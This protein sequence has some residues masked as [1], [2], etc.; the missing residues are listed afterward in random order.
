[1]RKLGFVVCAI[2]SSGLMFL[3]VRTAERNTEYAVFE[4]ARNL[5]NSY[6]PYNRRMGPR[7]VSDPTCNATGVQPRT[8]QFAYAF[9]Q[10][11]I[12]LE[13]ESVIMNKV[14]KLPLLERIEVSFGLKKDLLDENSK[15]KFAKG[16]ANVEVENILKFIDSC[17]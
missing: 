14:S 5:A 3:G 15:R 16:M 11:K 8:L 12:L 13:A 6:G 9:T 1:M 10:H 4:N 2:I 17:S 7:S